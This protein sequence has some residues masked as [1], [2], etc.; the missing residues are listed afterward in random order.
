MNLDLERFKGRLPYSR[1]AY[2]VFQP[3][4]GW[5]SRLIRN[6]IKP[7]DIKIPTNRFLDGGRSLFASL[8]D[9]IIAPIAEDIDL[10]SQEMP[11]RF[12]VPAYLDCVLVR[13]IQE[14]Y[15]LDQRLREHP[16]NDTEYWATFWNTTLSK[17]ALNQLFQKGFDEIAGTSFNQPER[18]ATNLRARLEYVK[19]TLSI[20]VSKEDAMAYLY[21]KEVHVARFLSSLVPRNEDDAIAKDYPN[22]VNRLLLKIAVSPD[23][24]EMFRIADP[25]I[26]SLA[27]RREA[28]LS[29]IG[30][31]HLFQ[32]YFFEFD[33][34][35]G[36]PVEHVWLSPGSTT[37]LIEISTRRVYEEQA[38]ERFSESIM[39]SEYAKSLQDDLSTAMKDENQK[40]TKL[41]TSLSGGASILIAHVE[42]SGSAS[43]EETEKQAREETHRT[44]RQQSA[45]LSSE[46]RSNFKSTF[47]TVK[48]TTDLH[49][50]RYVI[51]NPSKRVVNY[52]LRR[53]MRQV[54]VQMQDIGTQLCWQVYVDDAG[55]DL[56]VGQLV[57][58]ASKADLGRFIHQEPKSIPETY[59]EIVSIFVP[60]PNQGD[61]S[62]LGPIVA[63]GFLGLAAGGG[64]PAAVVGVALYEVVDS[65]FGSDGDKVSGSTAYSPIAPN[66]INQPYEV[67]L[68]DGY[69]IA[70]VQ[71]TD[72]TFKAVGEGEIPVIWLKQNGAF[73]ETLSPPQFRLSITSYSGGLLNFSI[74]GGRVTPG[75]IIEFKM[76]LTFEPTKAKLE[77]VAAEN[78]GIIEENKRKDIERQRRIKEEF[79]NS[80]KERVTLASRISPRPSDD[81]REEE[82]TVIYRTL[83]QRLMREAWSLDADRKETHLRSEL[84]KSMFD[85]DKMLYYV[86]PEWWQ[87][88][89]HRSLQDV[90]ARRPNGST[91]SD[92][93]LD[94]NSQ[95]SFESS[96]VQEAIASSRR[97]KRSLG[98]LGDDDTVGW[99]GE[100][101]EDNYL[102]TEDSAASRLGS[103]LGWLLQLDGDNLRNAFL[104]APWVKAVI[105]IRPGR[106]REAL[107]WLKQSQV[108]GTEGLSDLYA[109]D[110]ASLFKGKCFEKFGVQKSL[111][112]DDV[113]KLLADDVT[114]KHGQSKKVV[115]KTVDLGGGQSRSVH[116]LRPDEV[117]ETG[118]SPLKGG[119]R[120]S[121]E[122]NLEARYFQVF[123]QWMEILPTDQIVAVEVEYDPKTGF[124]VPVST[125]D[126]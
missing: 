6:R 63:S 126:A 124:Q 57:H 37:E 103:S 11:T 88:R 41:G 44:I 80:V 7:K 105:P 15:S 117:F 74:N 48:E 96:V 68:P 2:G 118:F 122:G 25:F 83:I 67:P 70:R 91:L 46:I 3:L 106:E 84:I 56:G 102:I 22:N 108:E 104:N 66:N 36:P 65:L 24:D 92:E 45:K 18:A 98:T 10:F 72:Q 26:T 115:S 58:L 71:Q 76:K 30:I 55:S 53:K 113:L 110:D 19:Q 5:K 82:R 28:V 85:V 1:E 33:T 54:G 99:G 32:Q 61:S 120:A 4:I 73:D 50:K 12:D 38:Y 40:N 81:L 43:I 8:S 27:K 69:Q 79:I 13:A 35:L 119:F 125:P 23:L 51:Q 116:Y 100:G 47:R 121:V 60:I 78:A 109:G 112:I 101:R 123:D 62:N 42:A 52:E 94:I 29:P 86:A 97:I 20:P 77:S 107:E 87:P 114:N 93:S 31:I 17:D 21:S 64:V 90:G 16:A 34:F 59:S 95:K 9:G 49:S 14:V 75:E 39:R 89:L 111:T